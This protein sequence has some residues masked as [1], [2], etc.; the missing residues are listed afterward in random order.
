MPTMILHFFKLHSGGLKSSTSLQ[1]IT[2]FSFFSNSQKQVTD[3]IKPLASS[4]PFGQNFLNVCFCYLSRIA[5]HTSGNEVSSCPLLIKS[6][7]N[8]L[9][10]PNTWWQC[11][12]GRE[13]ISVSSSMLRIFSI[14]IYN[15]FL[16]LQTSAASGP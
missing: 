8:Y 16:W 2:S 11:F 4:Y 10:N 14:T 5:S 15:T 7:V 6:I 3:L 1:E 9:D 13:K 12:V